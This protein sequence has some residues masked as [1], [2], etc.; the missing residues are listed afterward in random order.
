MDSKLNRTHIGQ[1]IFTTIGINHLEARVFD[2]LYIEG[3]HCL[4]FGAILQETTPK[5][6]LYYSFDGV[7]VDIVEHKIHLILTTTNYGTPF[8]KYVWL[9]LGQDAV[10]HIF[11]TETVA[12]EQ[13]IRIPDRMMK[14]HSETIQTFRRQVNKVINAAS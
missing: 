8:H 4:E 12:E 14:E 9:F 2:G 13:R 1:Q 11:S 6:R 10:R 5:Y 7:G 3:P